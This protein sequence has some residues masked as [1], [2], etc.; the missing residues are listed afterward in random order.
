MLSNPGAVPFT[1]KPLDPVSYN[2]ECGRC[3]GTFK[4]P[5]AHH[6][7]I[8]KRCVLKMDHHC[9]SREERRRG[10]EVER[11]EGERKGKEGKKREEKVRPT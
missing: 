7:S 9:E 4:P 5:R 6:C 3:H 1:A 10:G 2:K 11:Q 8:C